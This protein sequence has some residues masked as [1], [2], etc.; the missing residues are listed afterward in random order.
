MY[1][2]RRSTIKHV[3]AEAGVSAQTVS[4]VVNERPDV[5]PETRKRVQEVI[6]RLGYQPSAL[7]RSLLG[8]R[9]HTIGV[10]G[11]GVEYYGPSR[12]L[13]GIEK[14]AAALGF[15]VLLAL[16]HEPA[17]MDIAPVLSDMLAR[18]VEGIIWAV[19]EIAENRN[20]IHS[21][22][23]PPVPIVFL[24]MQPQ[25]DIP[26]VSLANRAGGRLATEHLLMQGYEHVALITGPLDWWE[27]RQ[28]RLGWEDALTAAGRAVDARQIV[29]G[30]WSAA[31]GERAFA[32]L[33]EQFPEMDAVF[34]SNDQMAQG[35]L[36][37]AWTANVR[38]PDD[39]AVVGFD[40]IPEAAYFIPPLTTVRQ[41]STELGGTAVRV[42]V[43]LIAAWHET[44]RIATL[45]SIWLQP[46]LVSRRSSRPAERARPLRAAK[47]E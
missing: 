22:V 8:Q 40:D 35:V 2:S 27:S 24:T 13:A 46:E 43:R 16:L 32:T 45:E 29:E 20:W 47:P 26:V 12:T 5:S 7:A 23:Q 31:S 42:L 17:T 44:G 3:A 25:P 4:R 21:L 11:S 15:S 41:D 1:P 28:R 34:A 9:T 14:Q 18:Q 38:V 36:H 33:R 19:P 37:A 10:V 6:D 39:L 30:D